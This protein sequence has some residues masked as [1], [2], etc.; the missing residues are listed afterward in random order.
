MT[1]GAE[2]GS[3]RQARAAGCQ[4]TQQS[5]DT[6]QGPDR[7]VRQKSTCAQVLRSVSRVYVKLF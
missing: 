2:T 7:Q 5:Q 6:H 1:G 4:T 3:Q